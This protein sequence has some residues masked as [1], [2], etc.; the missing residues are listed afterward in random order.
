MDSTQ[1]F[2]QDKFLFLR[3]TILWI[4]LFILWNYFQIGCQNLVNLEVFFCIEY[5]DLEDGIIINLSKYIIAISLIPILAR[6]NKELF[7]AGESWMKNSKSTAVELLVM[8]ITQCSLYALVFWIG[9]IFLVLPVFALLYSLI[10]HFS[11]LLSWIWTI[12]IKT[13]HAP[14]DRVIYFLLH[15]SVALL[16]CIIAIFVAR[17][18]DSPLKM[19]S[20]PIE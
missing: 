4:L 12:S 10:F 8:L 5:R 15:F 6:L 14:P 1:R 13:N 17:S 3:K 11:E 2:Y 20:S 9:G 7:E 19:E 16:N 18:F